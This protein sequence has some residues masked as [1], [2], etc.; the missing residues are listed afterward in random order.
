MYL[1][2]EMYFTR[3]FLFELKPEGKLQ[4]DK[5]GWKTFKE[6]MSENANGSRTTKRGRSVSFTLFCGKLAQMEGGRRWKVGC[7]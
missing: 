2:M 5:K 1:F 3:G 7:T 6:T 4:N